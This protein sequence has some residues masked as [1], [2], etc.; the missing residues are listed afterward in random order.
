[1]FVRLVRRDVRRRVKT[2]RRVSGVPRNPERFIFVKTGA[3][4]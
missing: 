1:M 2:R 4:M 3:G